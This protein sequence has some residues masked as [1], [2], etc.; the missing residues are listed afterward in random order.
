MTCLLCVC[1]LPECYLTGFDQMVPMAALTPPLQRHAAIPL[2]GYWL[3]VLF[4][5]VEVNGCVE[6]SC[7][8]R[9]T[10]SNTTCRDM[11]G[12]TAKKLAFVPISAQ[13]YKDHLKQLLATTARLC[14]YLRLVKSKFQAWHERRKV[15]RN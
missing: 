9:S 5:S 8:V 6:Y 10:F 12:A 7:T 15:F 3:P 1:A 14:C 2:P 13:C 4:A 11:L